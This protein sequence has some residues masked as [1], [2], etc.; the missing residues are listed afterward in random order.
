MREN[1]TLFHR[2]KPIEKIIYWKVTYWKYSE[3]KVEEYKKSGKVKLL[4]GN[5]VIFYNFY[6]EKLFDRSTDRR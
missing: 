2:A 4:I 5:C 3:A 1:P 6:K